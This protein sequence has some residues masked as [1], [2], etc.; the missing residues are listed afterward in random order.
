MARDTV[1]QGDWKGYGAKVGVGEDK[2]QRFLE[3]AATFL[4]NLGNYFGKGDQKFNP[5]IPEEEFRKLASGS[6]KAKL[7]YKSISGSIYAPAPVCLGYPS[8]TGQAQ[9]R[10]YLADAAEEFTK[11]EITAISKILQ[12]RGMNQENTR[13]AKKK[14]EEGY[15]YIVQQAS[16]ESPPKPSILTILMLDQGQDSR[17]FLSGGDH[18]EQLQEVT[19]NLE[20][21]LGYAA[22][23]R[24][25]L[26]LTKLIDSFQTGD[27]E[28]YKESQRHWVKD[29]QP[30]VES[31]FGFVEPYRD[32]AGVRA[33]FEGLVGLVDKEETKILTALA[34]N[35]AQFIRLLPWAKGFT[36]NDKK[37]PFEKELFE[38][39]DFTSLHTLT[40]CSSIIFTGIN[41]PNFNDIRQETG[42]KNVM[43]A[44][45]MRS[46]DGDSGTR[47]EYHETIKVDPAVESEYYKHYQATFY[48]WVVFHELL[49]HG[50]GK[51]L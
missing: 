18:S 21:A 15:E 49:G 17:V 7:L 19:K 38:A 1:S 3:Y 41:L 36:D 45:S 12:D 14:L 24:Q 13:L 25:K 30:S 51:L 28:Q 8:E 50:T 35:S 6:E 29:I 39:P 32:P 9:S 47:Q 42:F 43:I 23:E 46:P 22:N 5:Q 16:T 4:H 2:V 11:D 34:A 33:E 44:N 48:L 31:I 10:Y 37:G 26:T 27:M 20:A 40:Y